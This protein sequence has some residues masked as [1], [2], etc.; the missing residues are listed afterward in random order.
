MKQNLPSLT[1]ASVAVISSLRWHTGEK[2]AILQ[3]ELLRNLPRRFMIPFVWIYIQLI[4]SHAFITKCYLGFIK[5]LLGSRQF[6]QGVWLRK[7]YMEQ[8]VRNFIHQHSSNSRSSSAS[9]H[10]A[11]PI[12]VLVLAAGY[13]MLAFRLA[14]EYPNVTF[15][16][17]DHPATGEAKLSALLQMCK[18]SCTAS[19]PKNLLFCHEALGQD[20]CT[21]REALERNGILD[22]KQNGDAAKIPTVVVMEGLTFYLTEMENRHVFQEIGELFGGG[23]KTQQQGDGTVAAQPSSSSSSSSLIVA[24]DF[25]TLDHRGRP[26]NPNTTHRFSSWISTA[27]KYKVLIVGEPFKWGIT[28]KGLEKFF[29]HTGWELVL[30]NAK[31]IGSTVEKDDDTEDDSSKYAIMMGIEYVATVQWSPQLKSK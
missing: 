7:A 30:K 18:N 22:L 27:M 8:Q 16:E 14:H 29:E 20:G 3:A 12:R 17:L 31:M 10:D 6:C 11:N 5:L 21:I 25:F 23:S 28:P 4:L 26:V 15:I 1:A 13:D 2:N 24:F 19:L 9:Q